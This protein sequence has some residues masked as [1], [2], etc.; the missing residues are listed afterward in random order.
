MKLYYYKSPEGN[1]GDDLNEWLWDELM[2]LQFDDRDDVCF[3]GI[4]TI[5]NTSMPEAK[6]WIVFGSGVGYG[7]PPEGFG[8]AS[9]DIKFVR[10]PLSAKVLGLKQDQ[11][12]TDGAI[13]L[14]QLPEFTP[15][16]DSERDGVVFVPHHHALLTGKW[17]KVCELAG[18]E[19]INPT[20]DA[21][22]VIQ[23][24]RKAKLV[25]ADAMH[26]AIIADAMR[27]P[28]IPVTTSNQI[29]TFKWC[30]WAYSMEMEY[31]PTQLG[32]SSFREFFRNISLGL[33]GEKYYSKTTDVEVLAREFYKQRDLKSSKWWPCYSKYIRRVVFG[34]PDKILRNFDNKD[35]LPLNDYFITKAA[36]NLKRVVQTASYLSKDEVHERKIH[37]VIDKVEEIKQ[38]K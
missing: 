25:I 10:G 34:I 7:Y 32:S 30:D 35:L 6:K 28:W 8:N 16:E 20:G 11:F 12:I 14:K 4:G 36:R 3:S 31:K 27:V 29:N 38:G 37:L 33:Y 17:E 18:I 23:K 26:A 9:W 1:F 24:I 5:I 15:L 13:L 22:E 19:F 2:P 21:R